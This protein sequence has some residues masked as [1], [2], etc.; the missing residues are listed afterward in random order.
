MHSFL[1]TCIWKQSQVLLQLSRRKKSKSCSIYMFTLTIWKY[2]FKIPTL[3]YKCILG[4]IRNRHSCFLELDNFIRAH[5]SESK[6]QHFGWQQYL[7]QNYDSFIDFH[8]EKAGLNFTSPEY[9][10]KKFLTNKSYRFW[11]DLIF[12]GMP[13]FVNILKNK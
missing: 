10:W 7:E 5:W 3:S 13:I 2:T 12:Q 11:A 8:F 1:C 9:A 4:S 6:F